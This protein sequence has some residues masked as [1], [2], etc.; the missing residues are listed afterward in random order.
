MVFDDEGP[1]FEQAPQGNPHFR[2]SWTELVTRTFT[3]W[4]RKIIPYLMIAAIPITINILFQVIVL[5]LMFDG[6]ALLL[7]GSFS[8]DPLTLV[9]NLF[10]YTANVSYLLV[11]IPFMIVGIVVSA[12]VSG[13]VIKLALDN[14]GA[15]EMGDARESL[16]FA[17]SRIVT[18][19][20][21]QLISGFI[22]VAFMVP[23]LLLLLY[24]ALAF[25][26]LMAFYGL[27]LMIIGLPIGF[28]LSVRL[29]PASAVVIAEDHSAIDTIKRGYAL[30]SG[31]F[32]H[33][34]A[35][36]FLLGIVVAIIGGIVGIATTP[37]VLLGSGSILTAFLLLSIVSIISGIV[38]MPISFVFRAV[39]YRD[40]AEREHAQTNVW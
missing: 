18:I 11:A 3:L 14:Y 10:M 40:L 6:G 25:D 12:V 36:T 4:S 2:V 24:A 13:A 34:F 26:F 23:G 8:T 39:L 1:S 35:G 9:L 37:I 33:I 20:V 32:W 38:T 7:L 27:L 15:P 22:M 5:W 19:I 16:S 30:S 29:S 21:V 17:M 31:E 28:Y